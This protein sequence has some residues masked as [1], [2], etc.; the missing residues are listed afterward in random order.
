[1]QSR[2]NRNA[3]PNQYSNQIN[4]L[5]EKGA[6]CILFYS[7]G[8][9]PLAIPPP[10]SLQPVENTYETQNTQH[11]GRA[12]PGLLPSLQK[13]ISRRSLLLVLRSFKNTSADGHPNSPNGPRLSN[14]AFGPMCLP[15]TFRFPSGYS[16]GR[17]GFF[18]WG[19]GGV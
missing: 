13:S 14:H 15:D 1:M 18:W 5:T 17:F 10:A 11:K 19:R 2:Q 6:G 4:A 9:L 3:A 7:R 16:A 8:G 12:A